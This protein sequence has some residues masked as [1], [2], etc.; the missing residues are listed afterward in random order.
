VD[1]FSLGC[2]YYFVLTNGDHPFG[3]PFRR[4]SN[5]VNGEYNLDKVQSNPQG[6]YDLISIMISSNANS[7]PPLSD[8]LSHPMF[9]SK[10]K[11]LSFIL[12]VSDRIEKEDEAKCSL[13]RRLESEGPR[14]VRGM[15]ILILSQIYFKR[16]LIVYIFLFIK[17]DWRDHICSEV[18]M[19]LRKYR[20]YKGQSVRDLLRALRNKKNHY[21]ELTPEAQASL[22]H[23]PEQFTDY[24]ITRFPELLPYTWL[25]FES[26]RHESIFSKYY[27]KEFSFNSAINGDMDSLIELDE[28]CD[29]DRLQVR[30]NISSDK[31]PKL[32]KNF[33]RSKSQFK[34]NKWRR[35]QQNSNVRENPHN[36]TSFGTTRYPQQ[37]DGFSSPDSD[38]S[39]RNTTVPKDK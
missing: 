8:I 33:W 4:Q 35:Q 34:Y 14:I 32:D 27:P 39:W 5:I 13:L 20:T 36:F 11:I 3:E 6:V 18:A 10:E 9:W 16:V 37:N 12:D 19:D 24:W 2:V 22:G 15:H 17:G 1:V 23:I 28:S 26:V 30:D 38:S 31:S 7:R 21:R 25:K 29:S